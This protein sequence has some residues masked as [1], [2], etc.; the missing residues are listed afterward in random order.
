MQKHH[1]QIGGAFSNHRKYESLRTDSAKGTAAVVQSYVDWV[2]PA[3]SH[4]KLIG[5]LVRSGG[6]HP[7]SIFDR[8]Y[9]DMKVLRFGR[10]GKFDFLALVGRLDLAPISPGSAYLKGATGP[11][12]GARL[13]FGN[14]S[15]SEAILEDWLRDLDAKL[16]VGMQVMED[17]LCNW[18]KSPT[19]FVHFRG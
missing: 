3:C 13:L 10:L 17:A 12:K 2:G 18:Q 15:I 16:G 5:D 11:L 14:G 4:A 9:R 8:V 1:S 19:H 7:H 6:N